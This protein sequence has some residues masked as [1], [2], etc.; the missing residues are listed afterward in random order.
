MFYLNSLLQS[1]DNVSRFVCFPETC[2]SGLYVGDRTVGQEEHSSA[3]LGISSV[4]TDLDASVS[5]SHKI[6]VTCKR[7]GKSSNNHHQP[8]DEDQKTSSGKTQT[9]S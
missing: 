7:T 5:Q 2:I 4:F 6:Q 1:A 8:T 9:D 3:P